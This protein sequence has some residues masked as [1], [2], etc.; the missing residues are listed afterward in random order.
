MMTRLRN[1][2]FIGLL[3][4]L[5]VLVISN[6]VLAEQEKTQDKIIKPP[7]VV[8][9]PVKDATASSSPVSY[10]YDPTNKTDPFKSFLAIREEQ[11]KSK[12]KTY[13]ET[14]ELS[15]L[16]LTVTVVGSKSKW[17]MVKDSKGVGHV[18]K[19]GMPIGTN[20]GVVYKISQGEI[21]IREQHKDFRGQL[22]NVDITK[23]AQSQ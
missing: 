1:E 7:E 22:Q 17:A 20:N 21:V 5:F 9:E 11:A 6:A 10:L 19:E 12:A 18:I 13:L 16:D 4:A 3:S 14:L 2:Y 23:V 15:Q 8:A